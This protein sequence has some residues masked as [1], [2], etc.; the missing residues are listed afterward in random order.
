MVAGLALTACRRL[1]ANALVFTALG[2]V[3][4]RAILDAMQQVEFGG[5]LLGLGLF[6]GFWIEFVG[7]PAVTGGATRGGV[8]LIAR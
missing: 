8:C 2:K 3:R 7:V 1:S 6:L 5:Y 4:I